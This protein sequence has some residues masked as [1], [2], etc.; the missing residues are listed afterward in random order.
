MMTPNCDLTRIHYQNYL[1]IETTNVSVPI[2]PSISSAEY[3]HF[4]SPHGTSFKL[5]SRLMYG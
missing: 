5:T 2:G 1:W 3:R 4:L